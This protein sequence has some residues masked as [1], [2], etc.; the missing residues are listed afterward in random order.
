MGKWIEKIITTRLLFYA[1][2][3]ELIPP[4][5]FG[6]MPGK[7]TTDAALCLAHDIHA[8]NNHNLF[9]SLVT[10]DITGYFNNVNHNRLLSVLRSKRILLP[11]CKWVRSFVSRRETKIRVDGY[12]DR[13]RAIRTGC[14]QGSPILGVLANYY[15][16]PLLEL[17]SQ[18]NTRNQDELT[19]TMEYRWNNNTPITAGL[20]VNDGSLYTASNS[21]TTNA[22]RLK[23]AFEIVIAWAG[24]NGLKINMN[25]VDYICFICPHKRKIPPIL[26]IT[27]PTSTNPGET[28]TYKPQPHV[29]WLGLIFD[30]KLS[31]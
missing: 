28:R 21:P 1:T 25:K 5:Q 30:S 10:F 16:A 18:E 11:I 26:L 6:A 7:S 2:K 17:F 4:N 13:A 9:T 31:F 15:S 8:V 29:K 20:F 14:P 19:P 23:T 12:M 24:Q 27:L 22:R 3:H